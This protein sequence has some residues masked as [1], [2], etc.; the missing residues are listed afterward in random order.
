MKSRTNSVEQDLLHPLHIAPVTIPQWKGYSIVVEKDE[1][2]RAESLEA[3]V[4]LKPVTKPDE[5]VTVG[6]ASRLND[7]AAMIVALAGIAQR[8]T[9][10]GAGEGIGLIWERT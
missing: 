6:S 3:L 9:G 10:D 7:E 1:R 2:S 5:T 8:F 4:K